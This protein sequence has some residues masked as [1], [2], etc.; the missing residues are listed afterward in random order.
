MLQHLQADGQAKSVR[1]AK[2]VQRGR[3][4]ELDV[5]P[6]R[7]SEATGFKG[8]TV[9]SVDG[10]NGIYKLFSHLLAFTS[11]KL[12]GPSELCLPSL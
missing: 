7:I 6:C 3:L 8:E 5:V 9:G 11:G 2:S 12:L 10:Q 1:T 4:E